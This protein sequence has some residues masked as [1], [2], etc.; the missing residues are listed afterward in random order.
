MGDGFS[1]AICGG[2]AKA[3]I[4]TPQELQQYGEKWGID[5][6]QYIDLSRLCA[7][8]D[9]T[10]IQEKPVPPY[11]HAH[12]T[13]WLGNYSTGDERAKKMHGATNGY[14]GTP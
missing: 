13:R 4:K 8:I 6:S 5:A 10:A 7:K 12:K 11:L 1:I 2:K 9:N 14:Q 3:A